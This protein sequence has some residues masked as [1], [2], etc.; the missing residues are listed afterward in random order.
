[1][2]WVRLLD[3]L[4]PPE[5]QFIGAMI[6]FLE[7]HRHDDFLELCRMMIAERP[8]KKGRT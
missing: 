5:Q 6:M 2:S 1:M 8:Q 3:V 4:R 7:E